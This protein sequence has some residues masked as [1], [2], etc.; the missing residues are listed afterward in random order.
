MYY[1][2]K[3]KYL[4][5]LLKLLSYYNLFDLIKNVYSSLNYLKSSRSH[6]NS[7]GIDMIQV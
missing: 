2:K 5:I 1:P 4:K 3:S 7:T 6:V